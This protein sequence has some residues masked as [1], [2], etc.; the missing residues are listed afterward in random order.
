MA[1]AHHDKS[2]ASHGLEL[3]AY[4]G[5]GTGPCPYIPGQ[6]SSLLFIDGDLTGEFYR[7]LL[8]MGYRRVG[9]RMYRTD[10]PNCDECKVIRVP[11]ATFRKS[12]EQRR[13]WNRGR[14]TFDV[15]LGKPC[16]TSEKAGLLEPTVRLT[17]RQIR[18]GE[19][20]PLHTPYPAFRDLRL[21]AARVEVR[22]KGLSTL[23]LRAFHLRRIRE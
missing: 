11:T 6:E 17:L 1:S 14:R 5:H 10:C 2:P 22:V 12:K 21:E 19:G 4:M 20:D 23:A 8:D 7:E 18:D 3:M 9:T 16:Y 13:V 15:A